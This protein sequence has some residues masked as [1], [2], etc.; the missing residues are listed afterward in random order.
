VPH[1]ARVVH[2]ARGRLRIKLPA[3][4]RNRKLLQNIQEYIAPIEGVKQIEINPLT[5]SV[6]IYYDPKRHED[7]HTAL[8]RHAEQ[9][10][11][12]RVAPPEVQQAEEIVETL[13]QD[14]EFLAAHSETAQS[15]FSFFKALN[16]EVKRATNNA[17]DLR[18][19]MPVGIAAY[20]LFFVDKEKSA[21]LWIALAAFS[22][23]SFVSLHDR[24]RSGE[25]NP[26]RPG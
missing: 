4:R 16:Q 3:A 11:L 10:D 9:S 25:V 24:P 5:G 17:V 13:E 14:A 18:L 12:F 7:F 23:H 20:S 6:L 15:I 19:L 8:A 1:D 22:F 2:H 21:P 26:A